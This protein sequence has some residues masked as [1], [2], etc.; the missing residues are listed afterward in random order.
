MESHINC[1]FKA[2]T[3]LIVSSELKTNI[4]AEQDSLHLKLNREYPFSVK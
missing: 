1:T 4:L 3:K 2:V